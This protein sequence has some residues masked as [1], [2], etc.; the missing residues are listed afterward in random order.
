M[1]STKSTNRESKI[2][3]YLTCFRRIGQTEKDSQ[4]GRSKLNFLICRW[5]LSCFGISIEMPFQMHANMDSKVDW[6]CRWPPMTMTR[7]S[8][9]FKLSIAQGL[10][11]EDFK[12]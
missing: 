8:L 7:R 11:T 3:T 1:S 9:S 10:V 6:S 5:T 4:C 12:S 2:S